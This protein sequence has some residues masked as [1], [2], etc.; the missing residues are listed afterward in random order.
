MV[1][2]DKSESL[3]AYIHQELLSVPR[4]HWSEC[5]P[6]QLALWRFL[7][8]TRPGTLELTRAGFDDEGPYFV[9]R[10][11]EWFYETL[12]DE[13]VAELAE[14]ILTP[15]VVSIE[16]KPSHPAAS[17][18]E[19]QLPALDVVSCNALAAIAHQRVDSSWM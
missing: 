3:A 12:W 5:F 6:L 7:E 4:E 17:L 10:G 13:S 18:V 11:A 1:T 15:V 2:P 8:H 19:S 14:M 16:E 9:G